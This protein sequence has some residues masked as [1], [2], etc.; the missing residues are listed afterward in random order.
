[1]AVVCSPFFDPRQMLIIGISRRV[2]WVRLGQV[3]FVFVVKYRDQPFD[4]FQIAFQNFVDFFV[5]A[6]FFFAQ[7]PV[8]ERV[9]FRG[10]NSGESAV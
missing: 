8:T 4:V 10:G 2:F 5:D 9:D 6:D 7:P 3:R 1:M